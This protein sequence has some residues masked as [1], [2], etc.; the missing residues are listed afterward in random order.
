[1]VDIAFCYSA[2]AFQRERREVPPL[3]SKFHTIIL[4]LGAMGSA[5]AFQLSERGIKVLGIDRY[6]P[7][8]EFGST[9]GETRIT[10]IACGEG[11]EFTPLAR[12]SH[13]IWRALEARSGQ[14]L[15]TLNGLAV[16]ESR[17]GA[18]VH[19]NAQF[20][21]TTIEAAEQAGIQYEMFSA[22]EFRQRSPAF[23]VR[24][25]DRIYFDASAGFV[26]PE[27]CVEVQ[28]KLAHENGAALHF[29]ETARAYKQNGAGVS[30]TTDRGTYEADHLIVAA[31]AW[32][33]E[34]F[35]ESEK[36]QPQILRQVIHWFPLKDATAFRDYTPEKF[37]A[38]V[39]QVPKPQIVYGFPA[40]AGAEGGIK[41]GTEQ[42]L[43]ATTAERVARAVSDEETR[44]FH[45]TYVAPYFPGVGARAIGS[46]VC[47]YTYRPGARFVIDRH[48]DM[49]RVFI[50]SACSGHGFKHSAAIGEALAQGV[51]GEPHLDLSAFRLAA[52]AAI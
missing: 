37:P 3:K 8:H 4:G 45:E 7:P 42:Y 2:D 34:L 11:L 24:E 16:I 35:P 39:W 15:M 40:L 30:V 41:L 38:F 1:L 10:R 51:A 12:R 49:D 50:V 27:R 28:L 23:N 17:A 44:A 20:L 14:S 26:R 43:A 6:A 48:P 33:P 22:V 9:H 46:A 18:A 29:G 21:D 52:A 31:G 19:G 5:A 13:E 32:L 47:L 36:T 25:D